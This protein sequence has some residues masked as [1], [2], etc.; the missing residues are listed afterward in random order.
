MGNL[1]QF[2]TVREGM[3]RVSIFI[4]PHREGTY[5]GLTVTEK[6][7]DGKQ[8]EEITCPLSM[9]DVDRILDFITA[10]NLTED[11]DGGSQ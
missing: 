6:G 9:D 7:P 1:I 3:L 5:A 2:P 8:I 11:G 10:L 4:L